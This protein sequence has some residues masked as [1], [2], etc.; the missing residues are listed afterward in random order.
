MKEIELTQG[1][2]ALIDDEYFERLNQYK[3]CYHKGKTNNTGY[4]KREEQKNNKSKVIHMHREIMNVTDPK[5][6]VDHIDLNGLNNQ[7]YNLRLVT[8]SQNMCNKCKRKDNESGYKGVSWRETNKKW[9]VR[10]QINGKRV[11]LGYFDNI[12]DAAKAYETAS[13]IYHG[14]FGRIF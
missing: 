13:K 4:A 9:R 10:I 12:L 1:F 3:W 6:Q 8:S 2:K 14:E 5:V 11:H 7:K